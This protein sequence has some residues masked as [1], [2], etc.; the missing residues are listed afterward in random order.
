MWFGVVQATK[1][2]FLY[3]EGFGRFRVMFL[4]DFI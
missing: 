2:A 4:I 3:W 1:K